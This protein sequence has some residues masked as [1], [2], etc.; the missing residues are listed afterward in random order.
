ML[1]HST[2]VDTCVTMSGVQQTGT[3]QDPVKLYNNG[4]ISTDTMCQIFTDTGAA[5]DGPW[6]SN[7]SKREVLIII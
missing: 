7:F 4:S 5:G 3:E 2:I 1:G 6:F